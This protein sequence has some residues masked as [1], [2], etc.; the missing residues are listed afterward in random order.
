M[1]DLV[2]SASS[3]DAYQTCHWRWYLSYIEARQG[4]QNIPAAVGL[5]VHSA[6]EGHYKARM[7]GED[8]PLADALDAFDLT[9][10]LESE[11]IADPSEDP[12]KARTQGRRVTTAYI[13][14]VAPG[15]EP[16]FVEEAGEM[17]ING[18]P[19]SVH[20]D[21]VD[22]IDVVHDH[23]IKANKPRDP[24]VYAFQLNL[25]ALYFRFLTGRIEKDIVLDVMIRL[26]RDRP[27]LHRIS[28]EGPA[29][30]EALG[31]TARRLED[32]ANGI[33]KADFAPTGL[34]TGACRYCPYRPECDY[35]AAMEEN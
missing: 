31:M 2:L 30:R 8:Q 22:M 7:R 1:D 6:I 19:V 9:Y 33:A 28:N 18:I 4:D 34:D 5:G 32:A 17:E 3:V 29:T 11:G 14:D 35:Y 25:Y 12:V 20:I 13:E 23:K 24:T 15:I 16:Q 21:L 27:Y 10:L 26:K